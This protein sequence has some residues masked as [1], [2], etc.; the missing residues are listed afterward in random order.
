MKMEYQT[1]GYTIKVW[2]S[3]WD[4]GYISM[5]AAKQGGRQYY[6]LEQRRTHI[7]EAAIIPYYGRIYHMFSDAPGSPKFGDLNKVLDLFPAE[8]KEEWN[9]IDLPGRITL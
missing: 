6:S 4:G 7:S 8:V 5:T 9:N 2:A 3:D 1:K